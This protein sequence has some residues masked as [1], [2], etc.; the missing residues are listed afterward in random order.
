MAGEARHVEFQLVADGEGGAVSLG[1]R[2]CSVQR[3]HQKIIEEAPAPFLDTAKAKALGEALA[4]LFGKSGYRNLATVEMLMDR[5]GAFFFLEVNTRLQVEH[6]VTE[7]VAGLDL[8]EVQVRLANGEKVADVLPSVPAAA[9]H[10]IE[11]RVYAE[12]PVRL[13]PSPGPL[14]VFRPPAPQPHLVV[15][16]AMWKA[17]PSRP[18]MTPCWR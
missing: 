1:H 6:G 5:A 12:D 16:C 9:G 2:D 8:V 13:L 15:D 3:R 7:A 11:A 18:S 4:G 17:T 14:R 10:A